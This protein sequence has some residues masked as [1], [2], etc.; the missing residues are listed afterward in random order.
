MQGTVLPG[1]RLVVVGTDRAMPT[2]VRARLRERLYSLVHSYE[3]SHQALA[4]G[5]TP[6]P[7]SAMLQEQMIVRDQL[8]QIMKTISVWDH[9]RR[10]SVADTRAVIAPR[11]SAF[12]HADER[13]LPI[14]FI[15]E[16]SR[17]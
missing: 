13:L 4:A 5:P 9:E 14:R 7:A 12:A 6:P 15:R 8:K 2:D 10:S 1:V 17:R 11:V 3:E 16:P